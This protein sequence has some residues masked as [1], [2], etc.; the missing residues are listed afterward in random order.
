MDIVLKLN[1]TEAYSGIYRV[2]RGVVPLKGLP[3]KI[4]V[5]RGQGIASQW[6]EH[7]TREELSWVRVPRRSDRDNF[8]L[9]GQ[10]SVLTLISTSVP[11][12]CYRSST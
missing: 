9:Q 2:L 12:L 7:P 10:R 3:L 8:L 6:L 1:R 4:Q 5:P 11:H